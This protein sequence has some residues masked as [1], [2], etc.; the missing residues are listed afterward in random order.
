MRRLN[1]HDC[2]QSPRLSLSLPCNSRTPVVYKGPEC[3]S[4]SKLLMAGHGLCT[5]LGLHGSQACMQGCSV[6]TH[7]CMH[8]KALVSL[9]QGAHQ[10]V[11]R[12]HRLRAFVKQM[13]FET[14]K[15]SSHRPTHT[16]QL[17]HQPPTH[18]Q[19]DTCMHA[20]GLIL[21]AHKLTDCGRGLRYLP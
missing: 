15:S 21:N 14:I 13:C 11:R 5:V 16:H 20:R 18:N 2:D 19:R 10:L 17:S 8:V 1:A 9:T 6:P 4:G 12:A 7:A 3:T